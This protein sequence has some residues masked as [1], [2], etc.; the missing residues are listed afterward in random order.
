L[1]A[2]PPAVA[3]STG[4]G[5]GTRTR[6]GARVARVVFGTSTS[7]S[8]CAVAPRRRGLNHSLLFALFSILFATASAGAQLGPQARAPWAP[9]KGWRGQSHWGHQS[10]SPNGRM[11]LG[12][13][14]RAAAVKF[15]FP[16]STAAKSQ[17]LF[18]RRPFLSRDRLAES[19]QTVFNS[20][21]VKSKQATTL[22]DTHPFSR[23]RG[24]QN[25]RTR[26][27]AAMQAGDGKTLQN[28]GSVN[29]VTKIVKEMR[30]IIHSH[31]PKTIGTGSEEIQGALSSLKKIL[32][33]V[34]ASDIGLESPVIPK[35]FPKAAVGYIPVW[36]EQSFDIGIFAFPPGAVIPL[37]NHP[38]MCVVSQILYGSIRANS[39]DI[40]SSGTITRSSED[41]LKAPATS[42]LF[43]E[44]GN[45]H[46]FVAGPE[47]CAILDILTPPYAENEGRGCDYYMV[48][49]QKESAGAPRKLKKIQQP[50]W[51]STY[52]IS[53]NVQKVD[54]QSLQG[55]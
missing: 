7:A 51:F 18:E 1:M 35:G 3:T 52:R 12:F 29:L 53:S 43:A 32:G 11:Q 4:I 37:H 40:D 10:Q 8:A 49:D 26:R 47:G 41:T 23:F 19:R 38:G 16:P 44:T 17:F 39:F 14:T 34:T 13:R 48:D 6:T 50:S 15:L 28:E 46:E 31:D 2:R 25:E 21:C 33:G 22:R 54:Q 27:W 55:K 24:G 30:N 5:A 36:E 42:T 45:I 9:Q 20:C